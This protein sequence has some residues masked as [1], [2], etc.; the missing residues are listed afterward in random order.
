MRLVRR[1]DTRTA[2]AIA[3]LVALLCQRFVFLFRDRLGVT[4]RMGRQ[5]SMRVVAQD[6]HIHLG[7]LER[8][9]LFTETQHLFRLEIQGEGGAVAIPIDATV[10]ALIQHIGLEIQQR[11]KPVA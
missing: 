6:L 9:R 11:S 5:G 4:Q 7:T 3:D 10:A 8:A 2:D 1:L